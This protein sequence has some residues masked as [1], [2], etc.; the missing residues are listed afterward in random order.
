MLR[1]FTQR[2]LGLAMV[3]ISAAGCAGGP[4]SSTSLAQPQRALQSQRVPAGYRLFRGPEAAGPIVA[5][6]LGAK[7]PGYIVHSATK[8]LYVADSGNSQVLLY[9]PSTPNPSPIGMITSGVDAPA[10]LAVDEKGT[11][12]V[13]NAGNR[14]ITEYP[15]GHTSPSFTITSELTSPY[16]IGVDSKLNVFVSN[17]TGSVNGY[18]HGK[19]SPFER[20]FDVGVNPV[21]IAVDSSDDVYIADDSTNTVYVIPSGGSTAHPSGLTGLDAPIGLAFDGY[22]A[23]F[24]ANLQ[25]NS[26]GI[27]P[28]GATSPAKTI[29]SGLN[30]PTLN[31]FAKPGTFFQSNQGNAEV[32][33]Y[34]KHRGP[35]FSIITGISQPLGIASYPRAK[36]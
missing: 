12:Y 9:D 29:T 30:Q 15:T 5:R 8:I 1:T 34:K 13:V 2:E 36:V 21:G 27:Y 19:K 28:K 18:R 10:G 4:L 17:L 25:G 11:L 31:G 14:S 33:G 26:V 23:L 35:P 22:D 32:L 3:L 6:P 7:R 20:I 24:V 16:G